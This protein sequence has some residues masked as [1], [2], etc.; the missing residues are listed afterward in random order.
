MKWLEAAYGH[1]V[2]VRNLGHDW[3]LRQCMGQQ[4]WST[5]V[6]ALH[7]WSEKWLGKESQ[8]TTP[9]AAYMGGK[10]DPFQMLFNEVQAHTE[11]S[12]AD[13]L[14]NRRPCVP[15]KNPACWKRKS[16]LLIETCEWCC[17]PFEHKTGRG[18]D[19]CFT[20][21]W[22]YED[23]CQTDFKDL[24]CE[25][26]RKGEEGG[27]VDCAKSVT[28]M[29]LTIPEKRLNDA[30]ADY[31]KKVDKFNE[32]QGKQGQFAQDIEAARVDLLSKDQVY[33]EKQ[34]D[35]QVKLQIYTV[36]YNNVS[37]LISQ[38][39]LHAQRET[40][41]NTATNLAERRGELQAARDVLNNRTTTL[42]QA[43]DTKLRGEQDL[44]RNESMYNASVRALNEAFRLLTVARSAQ[45]T[46]EDT[47]AAADDV[48]SQAAAREAES[49]DLSV[50][51]NRSQELVHAE[52]AAPLDAALTMQH[53]SEG[54]NAPAKELEAANEA[55]KAAHA[56]AALSQAAAVEAEKV[57]KRASDEEPVVRA[58]RDA[59]ATQ[60]TEA[61]VALKGRQELVS[62]NQ[63]AVQRAEKSLDERQEEERRLKAALEAAEE[64]ERGLQKAQ[65]LAE[66]GLEKGKSDC[67]R[68]GRRI[69]VLREH[70]DTLNQSISEN[71]T[72]VVSAWLS[73]RENAARAAEEAEAND[74][75]G[76]GSRLLKAAKAALVSMV[77]SIESF[78]ET[79]VVSLTDKDSV[80]E[81]VKAVDDHRLASAELRKAEAET[82]N[83]EAQAKGAAASAARALASRQTSE[84]AAAQATNR[85]S[86]S[87]AELEDAKRVLAEAL[88]AQTAA[89]QR[90]EAMREA[91]RQREAAIPP[92][93]KAIEDAQQAL[94]ARQAELKA[95][96]GDVEAAKARVANA[97][98]EVNSEGTA[99]RLAAAQRRI[100]ESIARTKE[101]G[102]MRQQA[103]AAA[104]AAATTLAAVAREAQAALERRVQRIA[105]L[106]A[107]TATALTRQRDVEAAE[108]A[109]VHA[110]KV[111]D[112]G[113]IYLVELIESLL[114]D[115]KQYLVDEAKGVEDM[116]IAAEAKAA[117]WE[118]RMK[119]LLGTHER[120]LARMHEELG[121][122]PKDA[123]QLAAK[124][125]YEAAEK[126]AVDANAKFKTLTD[127][128]EKNNQDIGKTYKEIQEAHKEHELA[129]KGYDEQDVEDRKRSFTTSLQG[130]GANPG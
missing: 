64:L 7:G 27:C 118:N 116:R 23:C 10:L 121:I 26:K 98:A 87:Q 68:V 33:Q 95:R 32:L 31:N 83:A 59:A 8:G 48:A 119:K 80:T 63:T 75:G 127:E 16:L 77:G 17:S 92:V 107:A 128:N 106:D 113:R 94:E 125:A 96:Q 81:L 5:K 54:D 3:R 52:T 82:A 11:R 29:C 112:Q 40:W 28:W 110:K 99:A 76:F 88:V 39:R 44:T 108:A 13:S 102:Q 70:I 20:E 124:G 43:N 53:S 60:V 115:E 34:Y 71:L 49:W 50:Q 21:G 1:M 38:G 111:L 100:A 86:L 6:A 97:E 126:L 66:E 25:H 104:H 79:Y 46:A 51:A 67:E 74:D 65:E 93:L 19:W 61:E 114:L 122:E 117:A 30:M 4:G 9:M 56:A 47:A 2:A 37:R 36:A 35:Y 45:A 129:K 24:V 91:L 90:L 12:R 123:E 69:T 73:E 105:E 57:L 22:T 84:T 130:S 89:E 42:R 62:G 58:A 41:N 120:H 72:T 18:S 109:K 55:E 15:Y 103:D 101:I 85:T 78:L 14:P